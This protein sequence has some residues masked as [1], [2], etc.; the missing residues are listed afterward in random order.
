MELEESEPDDESDSVPL[1]EM[2]VR[3]MPRAQRH[4]GVQGQGG[5]WWRHERRPDHVRT[6]R[7]SHDPHAGMGI[8]MGMG[9]VEP[10]W[11]CCASHF[12]ITTLG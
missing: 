5:G 8:G 11:A 1:S 7:G 6:V 4:V 2:Q 10:A 12:T 3:F 9:M